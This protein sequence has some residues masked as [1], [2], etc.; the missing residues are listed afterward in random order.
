MQ[1][2]A[3]PIENP[4]FYAKSQDPTV[5]LWHRRLGHIGLKSMQKLLS[6]RGIV[7]LDW[8]HSKSIGEGVKCDICVKSRQTRRPSRDPM[9][10]ATR[11][12]ELVHMDIDGGSKSFIPTLDHAQYF[13][14]LTDD[15]TRYRWVY[16]LVLKSD[17]TVCIKSFIREAESQHTGMKVGRFRTDNAGELSKGETELIAQACGIAI[18]TSVAYGP[19]QNGVA[20][21]SNR[22]ILSRARALLFDSGLPH[23]LW[24]EAVNTSVYL[25]NRSPTVAIDPKE[26]PYQ[27]KFKTPPK[28]DHLKLFGC[29]TFVHLAKE[30]RTSPSKLAERTRVCYLVGYVGDHIYRVFDPVK[31]T[32][33][34]V[35]DVI[36]DETKLFEPVPQAAPMA[37]PPRPAGTGS[38]YTEW[39]KSQ[40]S[41]RKTRMDGVLPPGSLL[42]ADDLNELDAPMAEPARQEVGGSLPE[43]VLDEPGPS[44]AAIP[45]EPAQQDVDGSSAEGLDV[46]QREPMQIDVDV[47]TGG[48]GPP[49]GESAEAEARSMRPRRVHDYQKLHTRGLLSKDILQ[50]LVSVPV[51]PVSYSEA[52]AATDHL[53]WKQAMV[54]EISALEA[55]RTWDLVRIPKGAVPIKGKWVYKL[56]QGPS[57]RIERYKARWVAKGF[58]Q[59]WGIDYEE[60]FAPVAKVA[61]V[62]VV[63]ALATIFD[64]DLD[65]IDVKTAFLN[66]ILPDNESVYVEAPV[67]YHLLDVDTKGRCCKLL[68]GLYGL[69]QSARLW[70]QTAQ[71]V[72]EKLGFRR[73]QADHCLFI[74]DNLWVL[75]YVDDQLLIGSELEIRRFKRSFAE[76]FS[77]TDIGAAQFYLGMYIERDRSERSMKV[78]QPLYAEKILEK[79]NM[80]QARSSK[81]PMMAGLNNSL[82]KSSDEATDDEI[83]RYRSEIGSMMYIMTQTRADLA[84]PISKLSKYLSN[85]SQTHQKALTTAYRYLRGC[86]DQGLLYKIDPKD[87]NST[88]AYGYSDSDFAGDLDSRKSTSG[89]VFMLAGAAISWR[90]KQQDIVAKSSCE[91]EYIALDAAA[92]EAVWL[93]LLL[94]ELGYPQGPT[95]IYEDNTSC[96]DLAHNPENHNR[97]KHIDVK[98][99]YIRQ[100]IE[101]KEI[102]ISW[103]ETGKMV[104]DTLTKPLGPSKF[105][106]FKAKM[107]I[108]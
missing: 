13:L 45:V 50:G 22:T 28:L 12:L 44:A 39:R 37:L 34:N 88:Q 11:P 64:F 89:Y 76:T 74:K 41:F 87:P 104:A 55:N 18:E 93:R 38:M 81:V 1:T 69:K 15:Y 14:L 92:S 91:A 42:L 58:L 94:K 100:L 78:S 83:S 27:M 8:S 19:E 10:R 82:R 24:N 57:G 60:S 53:R 105:D 31:V 63:L 77:I 98:F 90:S 36:F 67:G 73:S 68:K 71:T 108:K 23:V 29:K 97:T 40:P 51:E 62:R 35:R 85:P 46:S 56:K 33:F 26:T 75:V 102:E 6:Q 48:D 96:I 95:M 72:F 103:L 66:G 4:V 79:V 9:R 59:R 61:T 49:R 20:E 3:T 16:F 84:Y 80:K 47:P 43:V 2:V 7:G 99:H 25:T 86:A 52:I 54:E 65:Q 101:N 21:R 70:Y 17:A 106:E 30:Q 32:V 107:G 5:D